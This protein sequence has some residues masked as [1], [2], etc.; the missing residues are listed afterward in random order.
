M[1]GR[2]LLQIPGP[3]NVPDRVLRAI[4]QATIDHRGPEF[5]ALGREVLDGVRP[6]F[7]TT[8]AVIIYPSS[9]TGAWESAL[10]NTLSPGDRV[11][12]FDTGEFAKLWADLGRRLGLNVDLVETDWRRGPDPGIVEARLTED[13]QHAIKA[14]LVVHNETS[15]GV[16]SRVAA[17]RQAIDRAKHPA[18]FMVDAVSSLA[19]IDLRHD[20][21]GVDVTVAGSQKGLMLPPGLGLQ[22]ISAKALKASQNARLPRAYWD[23]QPMLA[24]NESGFFTYTPATNLL[25]WLRE[26]MRMLSEEGLPNVFAR[27]ARLAEAARRAV[28]AWGLE[29]CAACPEEYSNTVTTV[30]VPAGHDADRL[31]AVILDRFNMSLGTGLGRLKGKAFRLGHLGDFNELMLMGML[32]GVEMGLAIAGV[33]FKR[34]GVDAAMNFL[35]E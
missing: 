6:I 1:P 7:Q 33:P 14:V 11:L 34:G 35:A 18:L 10:V 2:H 4:A 21:W 20:E 9:G 12:A 27:H 25:Y 17:I 13:P 16:T 8:G 28:A 24:A 5:A 29:L 19:S 15:T 31:R 23:W 32:S 22:A 26:S 30:L 3:T